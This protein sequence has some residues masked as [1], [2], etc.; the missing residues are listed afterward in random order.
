MSLERDG[1][2]LY[3]GDVFRFSQVPWSP[4]DTASPFLQWCDGVS[5]NRVRGLKSRALTCNC[6]RRYGLVWPVGLAWKLACHGN[7]LCVISFLRKR[8]CGS[9]PRR[10]IAWRTPSWKRWAEL[11]SASCETLLGPRKVLSLGTH[12]SLKGD[13]L[14]KWHGET[15]SCQKRICASHCRCYVSECLEHPT[16]LCF[17]QL[18]NPPFADFAFN[19][20]LGEC[21]GTFRTKSW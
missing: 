12:S 15:Q 17:L 4:P 20:P 2:L 5:C 16:V 11:S 7:C 1:C 6:A 19:L 13:S 8:P 3:A 9:R 10:S 18:T 21:Y 14:T